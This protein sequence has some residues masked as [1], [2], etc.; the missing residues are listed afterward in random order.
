VH[1]G[2]PPTQIRL[3]V[4]TC[5][6]PIILFLPSP[7]ARRAPPGSPSPL[8]PF[9]ASLFRM[10]NLLNPLYRYI[11]VLWPEYA[12]KTW[13][14]THTLPHLASSIKAAPLG[15]LLCNFNHTRSIHCPFFSLN[16]MSSRRLLRSPSSAPPHRFPRHTTP[17]PAP[18]FIQD[19][20][21]RY[22]PSTRM[23][24]HIAGTVR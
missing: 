11:C 9:L 19:L 1:D 20:L 21:G 4:D 6:I 18:S 16:H 10:S 22:L 13:R 17:A 7:R 2:A 3:F 5:Y 15:L 8:G 23:C 12:L 24:V 14:C